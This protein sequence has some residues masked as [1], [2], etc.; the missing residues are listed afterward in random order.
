MLDEKNETMP[1]Y[2]RGTCNCICTHEVK[3]S[4][5]FT[6]VGGRL[7]AV[8]LSLCRQRRTTL[9]FLVSVASPPQMRGDSSLA[10][11]QQLRKYRTEGIPSWA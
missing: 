9:Q 6:A 1:A 4:L 3:N 10:S 11:S 2:S 7:T 5:L 8:T